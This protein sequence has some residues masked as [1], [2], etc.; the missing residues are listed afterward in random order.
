MLL[1]LLDWSS[2]VCGAGLYCMCCWID[3]V[4]LA[5]LD[6]SCAAS[7]IGL[8]SSACIISAKIQLLRRGSVDCCKSFD[9]GLC[10]RVQ[11]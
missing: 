4:L 6:W 8:S 10:K 11:F 1:A 3:L 2:A 7:G 9:C 5:M